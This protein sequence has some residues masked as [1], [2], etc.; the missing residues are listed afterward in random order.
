MQK[1][2]AIAEV[3]CTSEFSASTMSRLNHNLDEELDRFARVQRGDVRL[4]LDHVRPL[5]RAAPHLVRTH[6][7]QTHLETCT[8]R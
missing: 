5:R 7:Y 6:D 1:V 3:L 8:E 2:K 4:C